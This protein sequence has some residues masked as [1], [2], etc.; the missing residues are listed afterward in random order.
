MK[1]KSHQSMVRTCNPM[2]SY[3]S[4]YPLIVTR[5]CMSDPTFPTLNVLPFTLTVMLFGKT[6]LYR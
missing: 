5:D 6:V 1:Q 3:L 4:A 2:F